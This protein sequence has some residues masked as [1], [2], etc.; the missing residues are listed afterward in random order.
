MSSV[1]FHTSGDPALDR[2]LDWA[3]AYLEGDSAEDLAAAEGMLSD[4]T[5]E[6][7][8]FLAAWFLLGEARERTSNPAEAASAYRQVLELDPQD[9]LGAGLRLARLGAGDVAGAMSP[10]FVRH[11]FDQY[12]PRFDTALREGLAYRGPELLADAVLRACDV[13]GRAPRFPRLLD[14]GCGTGL[15]APLFAPMADKMAGVDLSP[16]MIDRAA[17]LGLYAE[18]AADEMGAFLA[19]R[20]A[21]TADLIIAADALCYVGDLAPIF[22]AAKHALVPAGLLA[23]T[24]ETHNGEGMILRDTLRYAH[25]AALVEDALRGAGFAVVELSPQS[26]RTEKGAPVP[27]LVCVAR[28]V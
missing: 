16:A 9:R 8:N 28:L 21:G 24:V 12:A 15:A 13:L 2:R 19:R 10:A 20:G 11:L 1:P 7:P 26:T 22:A 5:L 18:L 14:L 23:F 6:A 3:R 4:L 25:G 17:M 27:G